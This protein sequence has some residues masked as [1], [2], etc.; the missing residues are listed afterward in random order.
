M[1]IQEKK[2]N[3]Y[4]LDEH[5][6][7]FISKIEKKENEIIE[8]SLK[9]DNSFGKYFLILT[10]QK[11]NSI[12]D[13]IPGLI[14][15]SDI[16][17]NDFLDCFN[18]SYLVKINQI[19]A[20]DKR[21]DVEN[22][23]NSN[24]KNELEKF[25]KFDKLL[26]K[27]LKEKSMDINLEEYSIKAIDNNEVLNNE[28]KEE[29]S[30][31]EIFFIAKTMYSNFKFINR[32]KYNL[33]IEEKQFELNKII[34]KLFLFGYLKNDGNLDK[35]NENNDYWNFLDISFK[36]YNKMIKKQ[37][38]TIQKSKVQDKVDPKEVDIL[39]DSMTI[40]EHRRNFL[41]RLNN[42]RT[43][44]QFNMPLE[45]FGYITKV[46]SAISKNIFYENEKGENIFDFSNSSLIII[47]SQTYYCL[48]N[49]KKIYIQTELNK[50]EIFHKDNFWSLFLKTMIDKEFESLKMN[51]NNMKKAGDIIFSQILSFVNG[52][53][54]F[55][56]NKEDIKR[57]ITPLVN[58]YKIEKKQLE[59]INNMFEN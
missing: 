15:K 5:L 34:N 56:N 46:F 58:Q 39:C 17:I 6:L 12:K 18:K 14:Q 37:K 49:G 38:K 10:N 54:G 1:Y 13:F 27:D 24:I 31:K 44:G 8:S 42:F 9:L 4:N 22:E 57:I 32:S 33:E 59:I 40:K 52:M 26:E 53:I 55:G 23:I 51:E 7:K 2:N 41:L 35:K 16:F 47:L 45:I 19:K 3:K 20:N 29:L 25:N 30:D 36:E 21:K 11:I 28:K 43:L 50:E 48:K